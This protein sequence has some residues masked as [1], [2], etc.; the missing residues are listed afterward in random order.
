M[1]RIEPL[2]LECPIVL[3]QGYGCHPRVLGP[4][5]RRIGGALGRPTLCLSSGLGL[6]DLRDTALMLVDA[7][8]VSAGRCGFERIDI[9]AHSMG[10][11]VA[12]YMLKCL[13]RGRRVRRVVALA[14]P[15]GGA[16]GARLASLLGP[17]GGSLAQ[18]APGS[19]LL[20]LLAGSSVPPGSALISIRGSRDRLVPA[21]AARIGD[22]PGH[23]DVDAGPFGHLQVLLG[24]RG[25]ARIEEALS[26]PD[27]EA[28]EPQP[29]RAAA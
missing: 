12:T 28:E 23:H 22:A 14:T 26:A 19:R 21:D 11:L 20:R 6:G 8:E 17:L 5:S 4:L 18:I 1:G 10:G 2:L 24:A 7:I 27:L 13:Y 25:F 29:A 15:F 9:V 3:V 16:S